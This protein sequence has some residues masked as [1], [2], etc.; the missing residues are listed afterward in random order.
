MK[1]CPRHGV[2]YADRGNRRSQEWLSAHKL[3]DRIADLLTGR[4]NVPAGNIY[5]TRTAGFGLI[6]PG[7][8]D[9]SAAPENGGRRY[10]FDLTDPANRRIRVTANTPVAADE[11][12]LALSEPLLTTH[13]ADDATQAVP[14]ARRS[15][16]LQL[17][18]ATVQNAVARRFSALNLHW[19]IAAG[20]FGW[21]ADFAAYSFTAE[22][23]RPNGT[24]VA[25]GAAS[26]GWDDGQGQYT[27]AV[28]VDHPTAAENAALARTLAT[29]INQNDCRSA[30]PVGQE[31]PHRYRPGPP[32][33]P[34]I[35]SL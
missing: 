35:A 15:D 14:A 16:L 32:P 5:L 1:C 22:R 19:R 31:N 33:V 21:D 18:A 25:A 30:A 9:E 23:R 6:A 20:T 7:E 24:W 10:V 13:G 29:Q 26:A 34:G 2:V 4:F 12:L 11:R 3:A 17:N 8:L 27:I 28:A